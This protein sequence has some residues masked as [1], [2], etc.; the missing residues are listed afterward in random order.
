MDASSISEDDIIEICV[1][2]G[3][4]HLLGVLHYSPAESVM[5]FLTADDLKHAS[6]DITRETKLHDEAIMVKAMAPTE[7]HISAYTMVWHAKPSKGGW[8]ATHTSSANSPRWGNT[9]LPPCGIR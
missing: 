1:K 8:K 3:C 7:A 9:A 6:C 5:L 4:T 2:Q